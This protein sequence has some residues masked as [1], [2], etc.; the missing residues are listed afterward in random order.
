M[1]ASETFVIVGAGLAGAKAAEALRAQGFDGPLVLLGDEPYRP[2]ERPPLSKT[3]LAGAAERN[4][5]FV[6]EPDWYARNRVSLRLDTALTSIDRGSHQVRLAGGDTLGYAKLLLATGARPRTLPIPGADAAWVHY[7][8]RLDDAEALKQ[9]LSSVSRLVV[10]GAG[11]IGLEVTAAARQAGAEVTIVETAELPLLRV[12]GPEVAEMFA[13]LHRDH[14]VDLRFNAVTAEITTEG[15]IATGVQ[16]DDSTRLRV[17]PAPLAGSGRRRRRCA[18]RRH[19][20]GVGGVGGVAGGEEAQPA[21]G[22]G[23]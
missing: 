17:L 4:S 1:T 5:V 14:D 16:L 15:G 2:Y 7:L 8:R 11:W 6:H 20:G 21:V 3:Y 19:V 18:F 23:E 22:A 12:H 10:I 13:G 9:T